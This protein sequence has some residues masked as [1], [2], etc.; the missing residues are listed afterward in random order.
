MTQQ[1]KSFSMR[2]S[3][4]SMRRLQITMAAMQAAEQTAQAMT[5][6]GEGMVAQARK[7]LDEA[8][9]ALCDANEQTLPEQYSLTVRVED[10]QVIIL[11]T[12]IDNPGPEPP[13]GPMENVSGPPQLSAVPGPTVTANGQATPALAEAAEGQT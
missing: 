10:R 4:R 7:S 3:D 6:A 13:P 5:S 9:G 8:L 11:D 12:A 2:V 1:Q